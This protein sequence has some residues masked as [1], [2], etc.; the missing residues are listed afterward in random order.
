MNLDIFDENLPEGDAGKEI[1]GKLAAMQKK[2]LERSQSKEIRLPEWPETKRAA[3][4]AVFRS[5]LFPA[6]NN[7]QPRRFLKHEKLGS[8][9]GVEVIFTGEQF[10][11]SDLDVYLEL[12]NLAKSQPLGTPVTFAAHS[13]LQAVGRATGNSDHKW[14]H[15]VIIRLCGGVIE[16]TDHG[17]RYFG[18]V[19]YGGTRDEITKQYSIRINPD[20]AKLFGF[21]MWA[22]ID[23]DQRHALGQN[24][25]AKVLHVFYASH[26]G[27]CLHSYDTLAS[28][29]GLTNKNKR[30]VKAAL[31][32]AHEELKRVGFLLDYI[33]NENT[34]EVWIKMTPGQVRHAHR[35]G[36]KTPRI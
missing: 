4:N 1:N 24:A 36:N 7:K 28:V 10:N 2:D 23:R 14:L 29:A 20:F 18:Q 22:T 3:P 27:H 5:G 12:L 30:D 32:K 6:L 11:Q 33:A 25:I 19:L 17:K 13:F 16:M 31:I 35:N 34:I 9:S 21:G 15:S 8:V 26:A